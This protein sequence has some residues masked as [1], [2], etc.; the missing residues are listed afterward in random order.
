MK[1]MLKILLGIVGIIAVGIAAVFYLTADL[2]G[3]ADDL[4]VAIKDRMLNSR[5]PTTE[6]MACII[7][8]FQSVFFVV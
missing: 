4:F 8:C 7:S 3:I 5:I 2:V 1:T 6:N